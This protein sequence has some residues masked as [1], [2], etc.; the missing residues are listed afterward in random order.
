[1]AHIDAGKTTTTERILYYTGVNYKIGEVHEGAATMDW[2]EQEQERGITI[3]SAATTASGSRTKAPEGRQ[4]PHQHHRHARPR[5]L[6][7]RGGALAAR[8]RRRRGGVR[9]RQRRRAPERDRV[10]PGR[11]LQGPAHRVHQQDGQGRRR[12]PDVRRVDAR[13]PRRQPRARPAPLGEEDKHRG[14]IDLVRMRPSS[15]TRRRQA[16]RRSSTSGEIPAELKDAAQRSPREAHREPRRVDDAS[17]RS[18][19][20]RHG[21]HHRGDLGALRKGT[22]SL[23]ARARALRLGL[24]EQG[25]AAAPRRRGELPPSPVDIPD[26]EGQHPDEAE[27]KVTRKAS[28][29]E[30]FSALAF[31]IMN[32]PFVGNLTFFR[33]YSGTLESGAPGAQLHQG[34][35][36][37]HRPHPPDA[38]QQA[39]RD[40]GRPRRQHRRAV[41]LKTPAPATRSATRSTPSSSSAWTSPSRSSRSRSSR[42]PRPT[43]TSSARASEARLGGS[44]LPRHTDEETARPSS[45]AWASSTSRSSS[46]ACRREFKVEANV[47]KPEVAYR[48][49]IT[50]TVKVEGKYIKQTGGRGQYGHVLD[51]ART[52]RARHGLRVRERI[53]GG[54]IPK[55]FIPAVEKG[56]REAM[57]RGVLAGYPVIDCRARSSTAA[58]TTSTRARPAFEVAGSSPSR[59]RT[60][61]W[62]SASRTRNAG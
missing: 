15:S 42:R 54:V 62:N 16:R 45:P 39:R 22:L 9:R 41:G 5:G 52:Q 2:M 35:A 37:A 38:R 4:A 24:Q 28:D 29:D 48:E 55:E 33:V 43:R 49:T 44:E 61:G 18:S 60:E 57:T 58:T 51:R 50:E 26:I 20:R 7:H 17:W 8:A 1:M 12:L 11:P 27:I 6:H 10:A 36:R 47:G 30:P 34:Q 56:I 25:R 32:D 21:L 53:V 46:T 31:K 14:I 19:S 59:R 23:Q 13:A 40:Q 3:T